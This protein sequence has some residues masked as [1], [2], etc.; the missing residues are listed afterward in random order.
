M[1]GHH[2]MILTSSGLDPC[3]LQFV[4]GNTFCSLAPYEQLYVIRVHV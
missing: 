4:F 2:D 1:E 3:G